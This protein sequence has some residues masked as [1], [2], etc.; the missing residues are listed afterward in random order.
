MVKECRQAARTQA[1]SIADDLAKDGVTGME[2]KEVTALIAYLQRLGKDIK[3]TNAAP[4]GAVSA[5]TQGA[6]Q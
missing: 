6:G 3:A 1:K 4:E 2:D 5:V